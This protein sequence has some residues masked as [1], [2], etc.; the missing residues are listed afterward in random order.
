M[1]ADPGSP[2]SWINTENCWWWK[3]K[4]TQFVESLVPGIVWK[5]NKVRLGYQL[6]FDEK[7]LLLRLGFSLLWP[8]GPT[9]AM[10]SSFMKFL[11]HTQ[12]RAIFGRRLWTS[13]QLV[14]GTS[15]WQHTTLTRDRHPCPPEGFEPIISAGEWPQT[16]ALDRAA[17][18]TG[19]RLGYCHLLGRNPWSLLAI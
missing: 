4:F 9:R 8:Y 15:I 19:V 12:W 10:A 6:Q 11:N 2:V 1:I 13:H 14:A 3:L 18:G 16:N 17:S 7:N 5:S